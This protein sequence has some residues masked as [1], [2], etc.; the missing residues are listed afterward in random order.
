MGLED[1]YAEAEKAVLSFNARPARFYE[2]VAD[3]L[4]ERFRYHEALPLYARTL[5]QNPKHWTA[6]RGQGMAAMNKGD[7][8]LG[9]KS[10]ATALDNDPL[11][12]NLQTVNLLTL[13][14]SYKNF[15]RVE[16]ADGRWRLLVH[17]SEAAVMKDLYFEH[18]NASFNSMEKKYSFTPRLPLTIEAF[19]RHADFEVRT[20]GI[21][22]LPALGACFGQLITLDSPS[23]RPPGSYNWASTLRHEMDHVFQIQISNGQVP[24]WL[25]EGLSVY[26]EKLT[27]PEWER[28]MEDQLFHHYHQDD[29]PPVKRFNEW[30]RDGSKVLFAYYL[31]NVMLEFIDKKLGGLSAVRQMLEMFGQKRTPEEVFRACLKIEPAEFDKRFRDYVAQERIKHLRM[32]PR[33][34]Q[35]R[36]DELLDKAQ[37]GEATR[38]EL[39]ELGMGY[40]QGGS[41]IDADTWL[42]IAGQKGAVDALGQEGAWYHYARALLARG[43]EN[44]K[45]AE[46]QALAL[47]HI[48]IALGR[49]LED[50][51]TYL[52]LAQFAQQERNLDEM[53]RWLERA[54]EAFPESP[55][56]YQ[57]L[58][59]LYQG[60]QQREQ[61]VATAEAWMRV[62][63]SNLGVRMWLIDN[64]Y[65]P[66]ASW[67]RMED[68]S[69][70]ALCVSPLDPGV[71]RNRAFALRKLKRYDEAVRHYEFIRRL[72]SGTPEEALAADVEALLDIAATWMQAGQ[73]EKSKQAL[74][75]ARK[76]DPDNPRI[77]TIEDELNPKEKEEDY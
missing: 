21:T 1:V 67:A 15:E 75:E 73:A 7:D 68:M 12:N 41:R 49:G 37:A 27:R 76:L 69:W 29:I 38:P 51:N 9:K 58:Y 54:R 66:G 52:L 4:S 17:K 28:H 42:G 57:A 50:F 3:G 25:A 11:R 65:R 71:H 10:L 13:L 45:A 26:E 56:P 47:K 60:M 5:E 44:L 24:R 8:V 77:K 22:G 35:D 43:N 61:A 32:V 53:L 23:A 70:Q 16:S 48:H 14:D 2:I 64:V 72:A 19:N 6:W 31:G 40:A 33:I 63:E 46:R 59:Q 36:I 20:V 55:A 62:D 30:F 34:S 39:V 74:E 18:L